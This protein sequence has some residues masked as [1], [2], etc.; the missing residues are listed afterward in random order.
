MRSSAVADD[1][2]LHVDAT[3][4]GIGDEPAATE[5]FV[6]G[7]WRHD[8][9]SAAARDVLQRPERQRIGRGKEVGSDHASDSRARRT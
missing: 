4:A 1:N 7:M 5:A 2:N 3:P 6:V 8:H 9:Q